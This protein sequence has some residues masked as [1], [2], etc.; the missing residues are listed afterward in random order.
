[1]VKNKPPRYTE[2]N[3]SNNLTDKNKGR[4]S[5]PKMYRGKNE[6]NKPQGPK[7]NAEKNFKSQCSDLEGYI[8]YIGPRA[9]NKFA[10]M[11]KELDRY[12]GS[13]YRNKCQPDIMN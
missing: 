10:M 9:S 3:K 4:A 12:L 5:K 8:F 2:G 11:M 1:M 6:Q 13:N 7:L